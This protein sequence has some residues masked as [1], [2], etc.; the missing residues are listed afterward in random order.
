M[1]TSV[2]TRHL[3]ISLAPWLVAVIIAGA[4]GTVWA[5]VARSLF[6]R[7]PALQRASILPPWRTVAVGLPC[8]LHWLR[9]NRSYSKANAPSA[10]S[11]TLAHMAPSVRV[12]PTIFPRNPIPLDRRQL[13]KD[14]GSTVKS[15]LLSC[16]LLFPAVLDLYP[17]PRAAAQSMSGVSCV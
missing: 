4:L 7:V 9:L 2:L 5:L 14:R 13:G 8:C 3:L 1:D 10:A 12:R 15:P 17:A 16:Q 6:S 11:D